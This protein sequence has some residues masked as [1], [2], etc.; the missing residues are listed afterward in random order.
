MSNGPNLDHPYH[1]IK[2]RTPQERRRDRDQHTQNR[3]LADMKGQDGI[4][5]DGEV[6]RPNAELLDARRSNTG[7]PVVVSGN[8]NGGVPGYAI[9]S[10]IVAPTPL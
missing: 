4:E 5:I 7:I 9:L 1:L 10:G 8:L 3:L 2:S 6:I